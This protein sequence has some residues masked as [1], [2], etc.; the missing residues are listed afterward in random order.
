MKERV[1][2]IHGMDSSPN[3]AWRPWLMGELAKQEIYAC[4]LPMPHRENPVCEE[5]VSF[6][7]Q[8]VNSNEGDVYLV[9]HSLGVRAVLKYLEKIDGTPQDIKGV[10]LI[11]GRFGKP[12]SGILESFYE[13][14][15]DFNKIK[16]Q[17]D[18]FLVIHGDDDPN[19]PYEDGKLLAEHLECEIV[20][21]PG[22]GHLSGKSGYKELPEALNAVLDMMK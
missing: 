2:I 1:F 10:V 19:V 7:E 3:K 17:C 20:T 16:S 22:G 9:G 21:I 6:I 18:K 4:S 12:R 15:L 8:V 5:W 13:D 11:S 14:S